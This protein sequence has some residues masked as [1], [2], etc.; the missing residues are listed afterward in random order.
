MATVMPARRPRAESFCI[1]ED[2]PSTADTE[3]NESAALQHDDEVD[4]ED[5]AEDADG[6]ESE[7]SESSEEETAETSR[8]IQDDMDRLQDTFAGFRHK[9]RLIKRI[10]E[11]S[12]GPLP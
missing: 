6:Q 11:G 9:Y 3:M 12:D 1:H 4:R 5:D 8:H 10:G 2:A 7:C